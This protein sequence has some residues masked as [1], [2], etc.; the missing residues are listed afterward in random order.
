MKT[1]QKALEQI[2]KIRHSGKILS[3]TMKMLKA[4]A[5][6][7]VSLLELDRLAY[8]LIKEAGAK[9]AFLGYRPYGAKMAYP[10]TI[11]A[12]VNNV[13]VHGVPSK[14]FLE[15]GDILKIDLGVNWRGGISDSAV[16]VPIGR[17]STKEEEL[18]KA[19]EMA[20]FEGIKAACAGNTLGDIGNAIEKTINKKG[21][22]IVDG[23]TGHGVGNELHE[24]P[25]VYNTGK[26]KMGMVLEAGM[27]LAL[28]PMTS[29][30]T[31]SIVQ[32]ADDSYATADG[33]ISAHFEHTILIREGEAEILTE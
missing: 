25:V 9:P 19:T 23:L 32:L 21:F 4:A 24:D 16:T 17:I 27:I 33:S 29:L 22:S 11:C 12:S 13:I 8:K 26:P 20:L 18:I 3:K 30:G 10:A 2:G 14:Y 1:Y 28:E 31:S 7:G 5:L 15:D 6:P